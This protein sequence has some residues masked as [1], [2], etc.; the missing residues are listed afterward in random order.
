MKPME[1][2]VRHKTDRRRDTVKAPGYLTLRWDTDPDQLVI[3]RA[4]RRDRGFSRQLDAAPQGA[5]Q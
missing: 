2:G 4:G 1:D 5:S 3:F